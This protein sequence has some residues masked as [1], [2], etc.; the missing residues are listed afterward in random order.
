MFQMLEPNFV[1]FK[2]HLNFNV[3][4]SNAHTI[5][6]WNSETGKPVPGVYNSNLAGCT[7]FYHLFF[8]PIAPLD[9]IA[10]HMC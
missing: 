1:Y 9:T 7:C 2:F 4:I 10:Y 5:T 6:G 3:K 8:M